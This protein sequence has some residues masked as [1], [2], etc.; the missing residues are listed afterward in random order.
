MTQL[1]EPKEPD[2]VR[3]QNSDGSVVKPRH[4]GTMHLVST[5]ALDFNC[6][7][8]H[9]VEPTQSKPSAQRPLQSWG[10]CEA[11]SG[12]H[13]CVTC[14]SVNLP[15]RCHHDSSKLSEAFAIRF[16]TD[17]ATQDQFVRGT[18]CETRRTRSIRRARRQST[19]R[20]LRRL[21][22]TAVR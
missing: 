21:R 12:R 13:A 15:A 4:A 8:L 3:A 22:R 10:M 1:F 11:S 19:I 14:S 18:T 20:S 16:R 6:G 7:R 2:V 5:S 9:R 17:S